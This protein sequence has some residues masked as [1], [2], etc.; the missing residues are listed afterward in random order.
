MKSKVMFNT[1]MLYIMTFAKMAFP[2]ITLP[3]LTRILSVE[4]YAVVSYVKA[5]MV[6]AQIFIDFGFLL[7]ATKD[8][9]LLDQD[10]AQISKIV[11]NVIAAKMLLVIFGLLP[12]IV[13]I[14]LIDIL[15]NNFVYVF[16]SYL[17]VSLTILLPDFLFRG[18]QEMQSI[19]IRFV[20]AR[21]VSTVLTFILVKNDSDLLFIP[22]LD[23]IGVVCSILWTWN[24]IYSLGYSVKFP[25][26]IESVRTL[27]KSFVFFVS[28]ATSSIFGAF[29]TLLIGLFLPLKDV[30][31]WSVAMQ[32]ISAVQALYVPIN[33]SLFPHMVKEKDLR[34]V[35]KVFKMLM[36][37]VCLG[38]FIAFVLSEKI[39]VIVAGVDYA[40]ASD[41][42][43]FLLPLL[44][45]CFP[46]TL[47][48]WP[49]LGAIDKER[50]TT[51]STVCSAFLQVT[52]ISFCII[53]GKLSLFSVAIARIASELLLLI[54]RVYLCYRFRFLFSKSCL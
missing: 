54:I 22:I 50:E 27:K 52:I 4:N 44:V 11:S 18:I 15:S 3:Y 37:I 26:I 24:K 42:F 2:L 38:T 32:L 5:A 41:I 46:A 40:S 6:Y 49:C 17:G 20:I 39:I 45:I 34:L 53:L 1:F 12:L 14:D 51:I 48:G 7:S 13:A 31:F 25:Q 19:T 35:L 8:V 23:I 30:S 29:N 43:K 28:D 36:P 16:I 21:G 33:S 9:A 10:K 47:F